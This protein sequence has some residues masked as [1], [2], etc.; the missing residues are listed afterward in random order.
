M[1][2]E[3]ALRVARRREASHGPLTLA[4]RLVGVLGLGISAPVL[5]MFHARQDLL[6]GGRNYRNA[7]SKLRESQDGTR[8]KQQ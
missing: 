3:D 4:R 8:K 5:L 1:C 6:L 2:S 7:H